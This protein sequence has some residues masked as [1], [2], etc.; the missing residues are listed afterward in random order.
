MATDGA[1][2]AKG[3]VTEHKHSE[4]SGSDSGSEAVLSGFAI[5]REYNNGSI[6][7]EPYDMANLSNAGYAIS[8]GRHFYRGSTTAG[9]L[10]PGAGVKDYWGL[11]I[12]ATEIKTDTPVAERF[13][14]EVDNAVITLAPGETILGHS[15]EFLGCDHTYVPVLV[16]RQATIQAGIRVSGYSTV[17]DN[18]VFGRW[19]L[20]ITNHSRWT[21][22]LT[23]NEYIASIRWIT[24]AIPE[25]CKL[26]FRPDCDRV[27]STWDPLMLVRSPY[28]ERSQRI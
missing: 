27:I 18:G 12:A 2:G 6:L 13:G 20:L 25:D 14:V 3:P 8:L 9:Y 1:T 15:M 10:R 16:E 11:P 26:R 19:T 22:V 28:T 23:M 24:T 5:D 7:I 17:E 4:S 21:V